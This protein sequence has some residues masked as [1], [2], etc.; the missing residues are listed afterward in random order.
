MQSM[1]QKSPSV[2][3]TGTPFL[4]GE[5]VSTS[6]GPGVVSAYSPIDSIVYVTLSNGKAGLYL[7]RPEQVEPLEE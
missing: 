5:R 3:L 6:F 1:S 7:F 4:P 2:P